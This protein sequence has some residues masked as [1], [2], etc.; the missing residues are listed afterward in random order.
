M[1]FVP[2]KSV[3][4]LDLQALHWVRSRPA[5]VSGFGLEQ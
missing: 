1:R 3:D 5:L 2:T 4:E